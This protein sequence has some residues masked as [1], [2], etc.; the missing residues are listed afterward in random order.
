MLMI[1]TMIMII[2]IES[3]SIRI[4]QCFHDR[5]IWSSRK[6]LYNNNNNNDNCWDIWMK[7][8]LINNKFISV[9][10]SINLYLRI[11]I[12]VTG[13]VIFYQMK[14]TLH[15]SR[16]SLRT[17]SVKMVP[18]NSFIQ[19]GIY[20]QSYIFGYCCPRNGQSIISPWQR[21]ET[22]QSTDYRCRLLFEEKI[23]IGNEFLCQNVKWHRVWEV[24][25]IKPE[26]IHCH[27]GGYDL[28]YTHF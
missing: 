1:M 19:E 3:I 25:K 27:C 16:K 9:I 7:K 17:H 26:N 10:K 21:R 11:T 6:L 2:I 13:N 18:I 22:L 12:V 28:W 4:V 20:L 23:L 8:V 15:Y 5:A 14:M 24:L